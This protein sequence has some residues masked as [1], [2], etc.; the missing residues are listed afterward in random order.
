MVV[1][2]K[3]LERRVSKKRNAVILKNELR[4]DKMKALRIICLAAIFP[5]ILAIPFNS[6]NYQVSTGTSN[7]A[8]IMKLKQ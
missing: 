6:K 7:S 1:R 2:S 4:I 5:S 8:E 3:C